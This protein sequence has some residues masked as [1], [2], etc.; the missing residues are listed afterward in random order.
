LAIAGRSPLFRTTLERVL[1]AVAAVMIVALVVEEVP[2]L[3]FPWDLRIFSE[4]PFLTSMLK[5]TAGQGLH[6]SPADGNSFIYS[7]GI[8]YLTYGLLRPFGL[9]LDIRACRVV[10][11]LV[12]AA[13]AFV[14]GHVALRFQQL[15]GDRSAGRIAHL[16]GSAA[17]FAII[18]KNYDGDACHPDNLYGL[19]AMLVIAL[20]YA[21]ASS[22]RFGLALV[23]LA[24]A[25][26]SVITKQTAGPGFFGAAGVLL[27][28]R[29]RAWGLRRSVGAVAWGLAWLAV[30][31]YVVFHG[32]GRLWTLTIP[33]HQPI[34]WYRLYR[35]LLHYVGHPY[36]LFLAATFAP[37]AFYVAMRSQKNDG[38]RKLFVAW[39]A[40]GITEI[41]PSLISYFK[42]W[43]FWNNLTII[44]LWMALPVL[45]VM[46][47]ASRAVAEE[48]GLAV[49]AAAAGA[50]VTFFVALTPT[51]LWPTHAD[52]EYG[53][54]LDAAIAADKAAG[55]R[56]LVSHGAATLVH[57]GILDVPFDRAIS[58]GELT[59]AGL[60]DKESTRSRLTSHYYD[61]IY[62][63]LPDA[64]G[65][66]PE[67]QSMIEASYH[68]VGHLEGVPQPPVDWD[69]T[70]GMQFMRDGVRILEANP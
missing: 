34:E 69:A 59:F 53:R 13:S 2:R 61:K 51:R 35:L 70:G 27:Y 45:G 21:A 3:L 7:G 60:D 37:S 42:I 1:A 18:L 4:S 57:N 15:L 67:V 63:L 56:V 33:S 55:K 6:G 40:I 11:V 16:V 22:E 31:S 28:F 50:I 19:H 9:Q 23:A 43:G 65:Y 49:R 10:T 38:L 26:L 48:E 29:G 46:G 47:Y 54:R 24:V 20:V 36:R 39:L 14:I 17:A 44:D 12:G 58:I 64:P 68:E 52:Y 41:L 62:I 66:L 32:W 25:G 5:L 8:E 30:A